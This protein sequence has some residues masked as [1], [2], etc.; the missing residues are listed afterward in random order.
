MSRKI[1]IRVRIIIQEERKSERYRGE[2]WQKLKRVRYRISEFI[3]EKSCG[4]SD[5]SETFRNECSQ[6]Y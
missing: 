5:R 6:I 4:E 1:D 2:D 3:C